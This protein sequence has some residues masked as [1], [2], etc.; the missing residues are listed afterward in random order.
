MNHRGEMDGGFPS[1]VSPLWLFL[2]VSSKATS[3]DPGT[4]TFLSTNGGY[5]VGWGGSSGKDLGPVP[6]RAS[7]VSGEARHDCGAVRCKYKKGCDD[8]SW[9]RH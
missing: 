6:G 1:L 7:T 9:N 3:Q 2:S 4:L 5:T 8:V